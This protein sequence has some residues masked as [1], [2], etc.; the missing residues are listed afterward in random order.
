MRYA[1]ALATV[2]LLLAGCEDHRARPT[3]TAT[4][5]ATVVGQPVATVDTRPLEIVRPSATS[6]PPRGFACVSHPVREREGYPLTL[7]PPGPKRGDTVR[8]TGRGIPPGEYQF[9]VGMYASEML[10]RLRRVRVGADGTF[11]ATFTMPTLG[12]GCAVVYLDELGPE[13][14]LAAR[15]WPYDG[16]R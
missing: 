16:F 13:P 10:S 2:V 8:V 14:W 9:T 11:A 7:D 15:P 3:A 6:T 1:V 4:A 5:T 12:A